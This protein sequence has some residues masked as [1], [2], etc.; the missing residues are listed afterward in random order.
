LGAGEFKEGG[1]EEFGLGL[2]PFDDSKHT[3]KHTGQPLQKQQSLDT[4][5][6]DFLEG[7]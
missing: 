1:L 6:T 4:R 5:V 3:I 2:D 7:L